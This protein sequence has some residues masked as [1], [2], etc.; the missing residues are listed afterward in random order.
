L[1]GERAV[2][3]NANEEAIRH[4][5]RALD[6]LKKQPEKIEHRKAELK[7]LAKLG[8]ALQA[9]R[10]FG[11]PEVEGTYLRARELCEQVGE[12]I[13]LFQALWG[14]WLYTGGGRGRFE[15]VRGIAEE[16]VALA[17]RLNDRALRLEA[18]HAMTGTMLWIGEPEAARRHGEQGMALYDREQHRSLAFLYGG[19]DPGVCCQSHSGLALWFRR[20][21]SSGA[22]K[23]LRWPGICCTHTPLS[24]RFTFLPLSISSVGKSKRYG[25]S[26]NQ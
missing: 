6:Q 11:P 3:H 8:P 15:A 4:F 1:T 20:P 24:T 25:T 19:H 2:K 7:V 26:P 21:P 10:G 18:H 9:A 5:R 17:E 13:E 16:L 23:A 12:S 22:A 14:L